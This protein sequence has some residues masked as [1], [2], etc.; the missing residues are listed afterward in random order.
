MYSASGFASKPSCQYAAVEGVQADPKA[1][2]GDWREG[3]KGTGYSVHDYLRSTEEDLITKVP[4][5]YLPP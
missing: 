1:K 3:R 4:T 2:I 5:W